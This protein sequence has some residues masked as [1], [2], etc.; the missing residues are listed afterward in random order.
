MSGDKK[1][2]DPITMATNL[3]SEM[4]NV[5]INCDVPPNKLRTVRNYFNLK[6]LWRFGLYRISEV[7]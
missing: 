7:N 2:D 6:G 1:Y 3:L 5:G 4:K